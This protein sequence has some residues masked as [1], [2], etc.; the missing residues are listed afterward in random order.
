M[1]RLLIQLNSHSPRRLIGLGLILIGIL[2]FVLA[3]SSL[4]ILAY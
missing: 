3:S 1:L 4:G 2:C